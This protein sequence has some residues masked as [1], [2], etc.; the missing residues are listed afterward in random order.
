MRPYV[1]R[2]GDYL[3]KLAFVHGFDADEVW[4]D[5]KNEMLRGTRP[6]PNIL[7][8]G[9][10]L[11]IPSVAKEGLSIEQGAANRYVAKAPRTKLRVS[12][13]SGSGRFANAKF[14]T[15]GGATP[16]EGST[17]GDEQLEVWVPVHTAEIRVEFP[18]LAHEF[19]L[20]VGHLD[21]ASEGSGVRARL[22][23]LGYLLPSPRELFGCD[24]PGVVEEDEASR[25]TAAVRSFQKDKGLPVTGE[26]NEDTRAALERAHGS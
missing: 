14:I 10:I 2:Q 18:E 25:V 8:P 12:F 20:F 19:T 24:V 26:V 9:D 21:P 22:I 7:A 1:V 6:D 4:N 11:Y 16:A 3:A 23:H 17:D 15:K 13:R 5:P